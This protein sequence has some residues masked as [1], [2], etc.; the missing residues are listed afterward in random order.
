MRWSL[1]LGLLI[2]ACSPEGP[3]AVDAPTPIDDAMLA[4]APFVD[5]VPELDDAPSGDA[6]TADAPVA[7]SLTPCPTSG[8]GAIT[9]PGPCWVFSPEDAGA[10]PGGVNGTDDHYALEPA[11]TP[12]GR[13]VVYMVGSLGTPR[14]SLRDPAQNV[15]VTLASAGYHVISLSYRSAAI[16]GMVCAGEPD[17]Y[18]PTRRALITGEHQTGEASTGLA[19]LRI[20]EGI[21]D[22]LDR[23]LAVLVAAEPDGG[24]D[25]FVSSGATTL[26]HI[27]W[28]SVIAAG[29]SQGGGHAA[30]LGRMVSLARVVQLSSTC[31][32][33]GADVP[34]TW[35]TEP[36]LFATDPALRYVGFAAESDGLCGAHAAVWEAM[37]LDPS[38]R[39]DDATVCAGASG[40][41]G[42]TV[43]CP[44]NLARLPAMFAE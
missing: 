4:D 22:R 19:G 26:E 43:G 23:A 35:T 37:G 18:G 9:A 12:R 6:P 30:Y 41:H 32:G 40:A 42:S 25:A 27:R 15:Y 21:L 24:W 31:D 5:D 17:C 28:S 11:G 8:D 36:E 38:R 16:V 7:T 29:H 10:P 14:S 3:P 44:E 1:T 2:A 39:H 34:A 20:D 13:L 33:V